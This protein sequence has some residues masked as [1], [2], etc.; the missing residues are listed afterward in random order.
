MEVPALTI[1]DV[2]VAV[3]LATTVLLPV[4]TLLHE[5]GHAAVALRVTSGDVHVHVGRSPAL[6]GFRLGRLLVSFSPVPPG[7]V[8]FA[9]GF[10]NSRTDTLPNESLSLDWSHTFSPS[11]FNE[12]LFS[13]S[14]SVSTSFSGDPTINYAAQLGLPNPNGQPGFPVINNIGV[15]TGNCID[16]AEPADCIG[17]HDS[18][19]TSRTGVSIGCVSSV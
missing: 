7:G 4:L 16:D 11:F 2:I 9:D 17:D 14:R 18:G 5:L 1:P 12:F 15:G 8:P 6:I 10:G 13:G 3:V 19:Q